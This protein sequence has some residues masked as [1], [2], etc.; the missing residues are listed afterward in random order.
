MW[1]ECTEILPNDT[2]V[3]WCRIDRWSGTPF[4]AT[5]FTAKQAFYNN[6]TSVGYPV[7]TISVWKA[8]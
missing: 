4:L 6:A 8:Q 1:N 5:Y 7:Y 3:V 2:D